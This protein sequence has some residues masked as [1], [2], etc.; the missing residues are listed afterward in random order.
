M[1]LF[2]SQITCMYGQQIHTSGGSGFPSLVYPIGGGYCYHDFIEI[3]LFCEGAGIHHLN[4]VPYQVKKGYFYLLMPGD[5]HYYSLDESV[6]FHLHNIVK[7]LLQILLLLST[8]F[9][10]YKIACQKT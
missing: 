8:H 6:F 2:Q 10:Q 7:D 4:S 5:Y 1:K 3:E 9:F